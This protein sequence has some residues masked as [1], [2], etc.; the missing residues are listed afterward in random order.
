[1]ERIAVCGRGGVGK[2]VVAVGLSLCL[3][4]RGRRVLHVG[5]DLKRG[6]CSGLVDRGTG[7][8]SVLDAFVHG[9]RGT[10]ELTRGRH[11]VECCETGGPEPG[12][13]C[14]GRGVARALDALG[15]GGHFDEGRRD[16]VIFDGV[17]GLACQGFEAPLR[18]GFTDKVVVVTSEEPG[19]LFAANA[20][21]R[22]VLRRGPSGAHLAGVVGNLREGGRGAD[23][24]QVF[25][26]LVNAKLLAV[27]EPADVV[28]EAERRGVSVVE[29]A[30]RCATTAALEGLADELTTVPVD[31]IGPPEPMS[32]EEVLR[33]VRS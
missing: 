12:V 31:D 32:D 24:V 9:R 25:A 15:E 11:G 19:S 22:A 30:P 27:L 2:S 26:A 23:R 4:R 21:C 14:A 7:V 1:M 6:S 29:H 18:A 10:V 16:A 3:G 17:G 5:C 20:I 13:G 33:L 8:A 28:I